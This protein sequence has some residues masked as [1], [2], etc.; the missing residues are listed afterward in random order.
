MVFGKLAFPV[1]RQ[2]IPGSRWGQSA[3]GTFI[4]GRHAD[5]CVIGEGHLGQRFQW[6]SGLAD[7][8]GQHRVVEI[9]PVAVKDLALAVKR[10][11]VGI[12]LTRPWASRPGRGGRARSGGKGAGLDDAFAAGAGQTRAGSPVHDKASGDVTRSSAT[13]SP[14]RRRRPQQPAPAQAAGVSFTSIRGMWPGIRRCC[15]FCPSP[16]RRAGASEPS[17][18]LRR[19]RGA[20]APAEAARR[21]ATTRR[22]GARSARPQGR[23]W[24]NRRRQALH[25]LH[26]DFCRTRQ[27]LRM[28]CAMATGLISSPWGIEHLIA[29]VEAAYPAP[30]KDNSN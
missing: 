8:I 2:A 19:S 29:L 30:K 22:T 28:T 4:A 6:C 9:E 27:M 21:S 18:R 25:F 14:T 12:V 26:K 16:R 10:Q 11:V 17:L 3:Q 23:S 24:C 15:G 20:Q 13:S 5:R 1:A 7:P